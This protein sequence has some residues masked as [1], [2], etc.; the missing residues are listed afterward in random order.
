VD[1]DFFVVGCHLALRDASGTQRHSFAEYA[2]EM[3]HPTLPGAP[4]TPSY[5]G[6]PPPTLSGAPGAHILLSDKDKFYRRFVFMSDTATS[7]AHIALY[8]SI[9]SAL[10]AGWGVFES[11]RNPRLVNRP[12]IA[13]TASPT[14]D[15]DI[16]FDLRA[17]GATAA[18]NVSVE[19]YCS[20]DTHRR[21]DPDYAKIVPE[22][23]FTDQM[24]GHFDR[25]DLLL[26]GM[27]K[28]FHCSPYIPERPPH[29][30]PAGRAAYARFLRGVVGYVDVYGNAHGTEFCFFHPPLSTSDVL[31]TCP[32][33][34]TAD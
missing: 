13:V 18:M 27:T 7:T 21:W 34:N 6:D 32:A 14:G 2:N 4:G 28:S 3:G 29:A 26:P 30:P 12:F 22:T 19:A 33:F 8:I 23:E 24:Y 16:D 17:G 11:H 31:A 9:A 5:L 25:N 15:H 1:W 20:Y 10:F